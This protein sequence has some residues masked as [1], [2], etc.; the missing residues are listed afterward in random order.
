MLLSLA[1]GGL[2][3]LIDLFTADLSGAVGLMFY[4]MAF[5]LLYLLGVRMLDLISVDDLKRLRQS[6]IR[7]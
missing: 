2:A 6:I 3:K 4:G 7:K 5:G 1:A